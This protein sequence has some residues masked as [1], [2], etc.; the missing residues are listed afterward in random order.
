[1]LEFDCISAQLV[2]NVEDSITKAAPG[3]Q[4]GHLIVLEGPDSVGKTTLANELVEALRGL[5]IPTIG[6]SFPG[7]QPSSIGYL[8]YRLHHDPGML[9]VEAPTPSAL[10]LMHVAAHFET[11]ER[12]VLPALSQGTFVV[13]DR[14]WWSTFVYGKLA[15]LSESFL[16]NLV[17]LE[18]V[19]WGD[20]SPSIIFLVDRLVPFD[21]GSGSEN[22]HLLR[23][24]Y[25]EFAAAQP[26]F[27]T[28]LIRNQGSVQEVMESIHGVLTCQRILPNQLRLQFPSPSLDIFAD[29][30]L[31]KIYISSVSDSGTMAQ[32]RSTMW[33]AKPTTVFDT[34]WYLASERQN[35]FFRRLAGRPAPWTSDPI[36]ATHKFTNAYRASDR[37]SQFLIKQVIY[38]GSQDPEEVLFRILLFKLFN[39]IPTWMTLQR[40]LG[41]ICW[42]EYSFEAYDRILSRCLE[43]GERIYSAAYIMPSGQTSFGFAKKHRNH[44]QLIQSMIAEGLAPKIKR[45][46]SFEEVFQLLLSFPSI[47]EFLAFQLAVDINYSNL[48]DFSEMDFVVAGPGARS[49]IRKC[50][51]DLGG[52]T[53]PEIIRRVA[54][55]QHE[56]FARRGLD[57]KSLWGRPLQLVDCQNLFCEVDKYSRLAHP[58]IKGIGNRTRIKQKFA[59]DLNPIRYWYPPKWGINEKIGDDVTQHVYAS[60]WKHS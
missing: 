27:N 44:L 26:Q 42:R 28:T 18:A 4:R 49:G 47:G 37:V 12:Q 45:S 17:N 31:P 46:R 24:Y 50:F 7:S 20:V 3:P 39:R 57:F 29:S 16:Q 55:H 19:A 40:Q 43:R 59:P 34:Y 11:I 41:I 23:D 13:L 56:E 58:E 52:L 2:K 38:T 33:P 25:R 6:L 54:T 51:S 10:Q 36:L 35:V 48:T 53:E 9:G 22:W 5:G 30:M 1:M 15:G 8:V 14:F 60:Y 32:C 21:E